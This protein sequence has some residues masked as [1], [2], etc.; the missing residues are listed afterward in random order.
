MSDLVF[1]NRVSIGQRSRTK[2]LYSYGGINLSTDYSISVDVELIND[3]GANGAF[4][5][6]VMACDTVTGANKRAP[7]HAIPGNRSAC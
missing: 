6:R 1:S 3:P 7:A 2:K 4:V 5:R